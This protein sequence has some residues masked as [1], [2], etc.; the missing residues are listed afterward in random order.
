MNKK[1]II[2]IRKKMLFYKSEQYIKDLK[3]A[4]LDIGN[5]CVI[6]NP[7]NTKIDL[8]SLEF[9][10]IG[11]YVQITDGVIILGHD[12]SYS[13]I[14]NK[15]GEILRPQYET[16]IG[17]NVF[18]G[19]NSIILNGTNIGNNV[20][21][22]A[23]SVVHGEISSN[24]VYAGNPARKICTIEEYRNKLYSRFEKSARVYENKIKIE[25]DSIYYSLIDNNY[26]IINE[27][28]KNGKYA[29]VDREVNIKLYP[30]ID[31]ILAEEKNNE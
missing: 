10:K 16:I 26:D 21:I 24:C 20:I 19:M 18:I 5:N 22:G 14:I 2:Q 30:K 23:G 6:Y 28:V 17:D 1:K 8:S 15:T 31:S 7:R 3:M 29:G 25:E 4:G 27:L 11:N 12:Y 9:I 13:V